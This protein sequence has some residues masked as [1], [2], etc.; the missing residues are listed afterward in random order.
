MS[1][2]KEEE[3]LKAKIETK[4]FNAKLLSGFLAIVIIS[5]LTP[6]V[7]AAFSNIA[8]IGGD[9]GLF[10]IAFEES[11]HLR[12]F[13]YISVAGVIGQILIFI[14]L[15]VKVNKLHSDFNRAKNSRFHQKSF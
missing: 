8:S 15:I 1:Y 10:E 11:P 6:V 7:I 14:N 12:Y 3:A 9:K 5:L 4:V 2:T 13:F